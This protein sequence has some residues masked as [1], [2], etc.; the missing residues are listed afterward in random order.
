[1]V[2]PPLTEKT[3]EQFVQTRRS[4]NLTTYLDTSCLLKRFH[5]NLNISSS[6]NSIVLDL[7]HNRM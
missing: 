5:Y 2:I 7:Q 1:M 4:D 3:F 6:K